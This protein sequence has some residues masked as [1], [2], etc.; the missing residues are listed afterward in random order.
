MKIKDLIVL[1]KCFDKEAN[2]YLD[3][4]GSPVKAT[5]V[6]SRLSDPE[7]ENSDIEVVISFDKRGT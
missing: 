5:F 2:V 3:S 1:L 6:I 7:D 4:Y